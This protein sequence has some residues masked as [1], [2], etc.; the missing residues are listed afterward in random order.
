MRHLGVLYAFVTD[1]KWKKRILTEAV[2]RVAKKTLQSLMRKAVSKIQTTTNEP[3]VRV[4]VGY[5]NFLFGNTEESSTYWNTEMRWNLATNFFYVEGAPKKAL[6]KVK[7]IKK[8]VDLLY[9]FDELPRVLGVEMRKDVLSSMLSGTSFKKKVIVE[10]KDILAIHPV[11]TSGLT[12]HPKAFQLYE[13]VIFTF[14][15]FFL[16]FSFFLVSSFFA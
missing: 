6:R 3:I 8:S 13:K 9:I 16:W 7:D 15:S 11:V 5:L 10:E 12:E 4:I 14:L 2:L 1:R